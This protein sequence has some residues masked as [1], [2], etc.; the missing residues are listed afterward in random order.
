VI[1][2]CII[3]GSYLYLADQVFSKFVSKVLLGQ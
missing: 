3:I 1:I 2:A